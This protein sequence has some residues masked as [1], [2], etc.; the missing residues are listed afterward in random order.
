MTIKYRVNRDIKTPN[1]KL[2]R[3]TEVWSCS[4][5]DDMIQVVSLNPDMSKYFRV[6]NITLEKVED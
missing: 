5:P 3:G 2:L 1:G 4:K 6:H